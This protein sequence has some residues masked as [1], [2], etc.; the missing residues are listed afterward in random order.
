M[1]PLKL[2]ALVATF[3]GLSSCAQLEQAG[4]KSEIGFFKPA[5]P[6]D[7]SANFGAFFQRAAPAIKADK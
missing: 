6:S 5:L 4:V 7:P 3:L 2:L 1:K